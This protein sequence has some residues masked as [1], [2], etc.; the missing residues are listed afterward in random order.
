MGSLGVYCVRPLMPAYRA[1]VTE[2]RCE[3]GIEA[4]REVQIDT[5]LSRG[6]THNRLLPYTVHHSIY[7]TSARW[8]MSVQD[9]QKL[10]NYTR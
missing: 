2:R 5:T 9:T 6:E 7:E 3:S 1:S 10:L 8:S 4:R